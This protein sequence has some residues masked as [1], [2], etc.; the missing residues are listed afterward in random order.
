M[1]DLPFCTVALL[2]SISR[3]Y[4]PAWRSALPTL[5]A[6]VM[7][8]VL[9]M[10]LAKTGR[11]RAA[12]AK[13]AA[14][15][16]SELDFMRVNFLS[17]SSQPHHNCRGRTEWLTRRAGSEEPSPNDTCS[18]WTNGRKDACQ[19]PAAPTPR[20]LIDISLPHPEPL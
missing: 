12:T 10:G 15:R 16:R 8:M 5:A 3:R 11:A 20:F 2:P 18:S 4:S 19:R 7:L 13:S 1:T 6:W 17:F 14:V 9:L